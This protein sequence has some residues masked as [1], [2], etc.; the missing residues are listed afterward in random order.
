[1]RTRRAAA[2]VRVFTRPPMTSLPPGLRAAPSYWSR[3]RIVYEGHDRHGNDDIEGACF[4]AG[5]ASSPTSL[6]MTASGVLQEACIRDVNVDFAAA[7]D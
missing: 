2:H 4:E 7:S 5:E 1:M 6:V 3:S